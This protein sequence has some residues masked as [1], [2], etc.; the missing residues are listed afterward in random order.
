MS[1]LPQTPSE[2]VRFRWGLAGILNFLAFAVHCLLDETVALFCT[3][4]FENGYHIV[5]THG[6]EVLLS[7][8]RYWFNYIHGIVFIV[9]HLVCSFAL[10]RL[11]RKAFVASK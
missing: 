9:L 7:S 2:W 1:M 11:R 10:W 4:R 3:S 6:H 5:F 8:N